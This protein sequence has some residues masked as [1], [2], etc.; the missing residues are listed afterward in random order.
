MAPIGATG[1][2]ELMDVCVDPLD[3]STGGLV[4]APVPV[5]SLNIA[6]ISMFPA[7]PPALLL[8][9]S[10]LG[11]LAPRYGEAKKVSTAPTPVGG[12]R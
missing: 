5:G 3:N 4:S 1:V 11:A 7:S 8:N 2:L 6:L 12:W 10:L 9:E